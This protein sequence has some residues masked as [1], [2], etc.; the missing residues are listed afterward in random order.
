MVRT[1]FHI[2]KHDCDREAVQADELGRLKDEIEALQAE[3][4]A[5]REAFVETGVP[6]AGGDTYCFEPEWIGRVTARQTV[7]R[8]SVRH[9]AAAQA[10]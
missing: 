3:Y 10:A 6:H 4:A 1:I 2:R 7:I 5:K 8:I 9:K